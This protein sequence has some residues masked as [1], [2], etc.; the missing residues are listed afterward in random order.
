MQ[1]K[2]KLKIYGDTPISLLLALVLTKFNCD[3]YLFDF[4]Q[5]PNLNKNDQILSFSNFSKDLLT[6]YDLWREFEEFSYGITSF[7]LEDNIVSKKLLL[8]SQT[9]SDEKLNT[10]CWTARY[11]DLKRLLIKKLKNFDNVHFNSRNQLNDQS[12]IYDYVF[13]LVSYK[14]ITDLFRFPF[15]IFKEKE[16][17]VLI[18][19]VYLRGNIENRLYTI[20]TNEGLLNLTP[21]SKNLYQITW[22]NVSTKFKERSLSS[23]S[24]FLDNLTALLPNELKIDQIVGNIESLYMSNICPPYV[25]RNKF[26]YLNENK[27]QSNI[28]YEFNF[29]NIIKIILHIYN[30]LKNTKSKNINFLNNFGFF[31]LLIKYKEFM[32]NFSFQSLLI[33]LFIY[34]NILSFFLRKLLFLLLKRIYFFKIFIIRNLFNSN[35]KDFTK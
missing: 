33:N 26:I 15:S 2:L 17:L 7:S 5:N 14:N 24:F 21:L 9:L 29:D 16:S 23:K 11:S 1:R 31:Y 13:K 35:I 25:I 10:I 8:R 30:L 19:N 20:N 32:A 4:L 34:N 3:I 12:L 28:L 22:N 27:F 18:F 6:K